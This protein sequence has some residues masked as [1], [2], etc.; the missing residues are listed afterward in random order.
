LQ[1]FR[2]A[3]PAEGWELIRQIR[4]DIVILDLVMPEINGMELLDRI[5]EWDSAI[6]VVLLSSEYSTE[7]AVEAIRKG[8]CDY[9]TKPISALV[10]RE[11]IGTLI[12]LANTR[13][14]TSQLSDE[15]LNRSRFGEM[16]GSSPPM[17]EV[18]SRIRRIGPHFRIALIT[19]ATGT[20]KELVAR[21]LHK[22]SPVSG[23]PFIVCNCAAIVETLFESELF[24]YVRGAFT[25]AMQDRPGFFE[26]ADGGTLFMDEIGEIPLHLQSK[27]LRALQNNEIQR[28]GSHALRKVEVRV[29]AATN[30]DLRELAN[31]KLFREDLFFRLSMLEIKL[32]T[33]AERKEDLPLLQKF[34]LD[35]FAAQLGR[36]V[37]GLTRRAQSVLSRYFWPGNIRELQNVIGH[38]CM[39]SA[40]DMI[41][42]PDLPDY[43]HSRESA[44]E[45]QGLL[46]L[47]EVE[48]RHVHSVLT[49][50][51]GNKQEAAEILGISRATIYRILS[52]KDGE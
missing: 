31:K 39:M 40:G 23:K 32:P 11:R 25:G 36:S 15:M 38:A 17:L 4:P 43:L 24:G 52:Q 33:L 20:G 3:D 7:R 13:T 42:L 35:Q 29:I 10:L 28:V 50:V 14:R 47:E 34:F 51:G 8:A 9:L 37:K 26:A 16:V 22:Y 2:S 41:D 19:G 1:I 45:G 27:L 49:Q 30:R 6:E 5:V 48:K 46:T 12:S 18:Y 44:R 21:A